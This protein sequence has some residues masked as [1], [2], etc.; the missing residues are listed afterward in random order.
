MRRLDAAMIV[1]NF[2]EAPMKLGSSHKGNGEVH[3]VKLYDDHDFASPLKFLY[4]MVM[5]PGTSIGYHQHGQNE[6]MYLVLEGT[7]RMTVNG[8]E[9][10]VKPG[11]V[12]LNRAGWSHGLENT[13]SEP[14]R[15]L[16]YE[17]DLVPASG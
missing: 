3:S 6:E 12:L 10:D 11:D 15:L 14:I 1:R 4:Y 17:A 5:P 8:E 13:G 7:G 16:I 9:R 2:L